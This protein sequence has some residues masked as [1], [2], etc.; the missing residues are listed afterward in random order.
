MLNLMPSQIMGF[1]EDKQESIFNL[2]KQR[3]I[4]LN[5]DL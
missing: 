5:R 3:E 2:I 1:E 4:Q